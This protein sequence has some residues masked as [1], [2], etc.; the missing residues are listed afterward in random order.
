MPPSALATG[1]LECVAQSLCL[2]NSAA[3]DMVNVLSLL[4]LGSAT[5]APNSMQEDRCRLEPGL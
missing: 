3:L 5:D 4:T 1:A 2:S